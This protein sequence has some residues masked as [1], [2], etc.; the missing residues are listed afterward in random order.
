[1][2]VRK[3]ETGW[4]ARWIN[5]NISLTRKRVKE[6]IQV[7]IENRFCFQQK[8]RTCL[9]KIISWDLLKQFKVRVT[10]TT[11]NNARRLDL[12]KVILENELR[13]VETSFISSTRNFRRELSSKQTEKLHS[14]FKIIP[15]E[16][17]VQAS[18]SSVAYITAI[19]FDSVFN[20]FFHSLET[21][22]FL[23]SLPVMWFPSSALTL[24]FRM[25][26]LVISW[27]S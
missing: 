24:S 11:C 15:H 16:L 27:Q 6:M 9:R 19:I 12:C 20:S 22:F 3:K 4:S 10:G 26:A 23:H 7:C 13:A 8:H 1:M 5:R 14:E 2:N 18:F 17:W 21:R 25:P